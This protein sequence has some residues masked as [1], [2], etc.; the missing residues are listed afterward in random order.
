MR[1]CILPVYLLALC[2][3]AAC[4]PTCIHIHI[5]TYIRS[6]NIDL[7]MRR[8]HL[9]L[10]STYLGIHTIRVRVLHIIIVR[11][12]H[13]SLLIT[14]SNSLSVRL[15]WRTLL[16]HGS[17]HPICQPAWTL[18]P[19]TACLLFFLAQTAGRLMESYFSH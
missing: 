2:I 3:G 9:T 6:T 17:I 1:T 8:V 4:M 10:T 15:A 13:P 12:H 19:S 18:K 14:S 16:C 7:D 5:H 11:S